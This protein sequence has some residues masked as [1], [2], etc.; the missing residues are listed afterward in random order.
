MT[1]QSVAELISSG[2]PD[3]KILLA[4]MNGRKSDEY[5]REALSGIDTMKLH[6]DNKTMSGADF[7]RTC[8]HK[9]RF[10]ILGGISNEMEE[11]YYS[12]SM[13][14][15]LLEEIAPEFDIVIADTGNVLDNGLAV[16]TLSISAEIFLILTQQESAIKRYEKN[17]SIID[18]LEIGI[19]AY[20]INKYF[21]ED[22]YG[23]N[24]IAD[25]ME[26]EKEKIWKLNSADYSRQAE[27]EYKTLL[28][29]KNEA[30]MQGIT[31]IANYILIKNGFAEIKSQRKSRWKSFI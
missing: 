6:I 1:A 19:S 17:R 14:Q 27:I 7:L 23:I 12:P 22:P 24:Y 10:Y 28:E 4:S 16:G 25:R 9:G 31:G 2:Y 20:V 18:A 15:Y 21:E 8:T 5:I 30:Y 11:R 26:V 29:Y 3:L 13:V